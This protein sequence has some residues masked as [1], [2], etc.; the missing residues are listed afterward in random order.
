MS[1]VT[2]DQPLWS[3]VLHNNNNNKT[4]ICKAP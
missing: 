4:A 3:P 2:I 1:Q